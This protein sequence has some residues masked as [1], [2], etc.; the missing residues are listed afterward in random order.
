M[1]YQNSSLKDQIDLLPTLGFDQIEQREYLR[2]DPKY[3]KK[4]YDFRIYKYNEKEL[5]NLNNL[6]Q[7]SKESDREL[8]FKIAFK[9]RNPEG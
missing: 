6:Y 1:N 8:D 5:E 2:I 7:K 3:L 4:I 9:S